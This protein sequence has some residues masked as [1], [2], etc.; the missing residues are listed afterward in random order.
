M[1]NGSGG[2]A[3]RFA[4]RLLGT[5]ARVTLRRNWR[6]SGTVVIVASMLLTAGCNGV[7]GLSD[8]EP[9]PSSA[10]SVQEVGQRALAGL[11]ASNAAD[12]ELLRLTEHEHND[13]LWPELPASDP[14]LNVPLDWAW[15][16]IETRNQAALRRIERWF[17]G[18]DLEFEN[19]ECVGETQ[20]FRTFRVLTDCWVAFRLLQAGEDASET[21]EARVQLFKDVVE[22]GGGYKIFRFYDNEPV[23]V[24]EDGRGRGRASLARRGS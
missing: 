7:P 11:V 21:K 8:V 5:R 2:G 3:G 16:D 17:Q 19:A 18:R 24:A 9:F 1:W 15:G 12:L 6:K 4:R 14:A 10:G 22:R 13:V 23:P 20:E